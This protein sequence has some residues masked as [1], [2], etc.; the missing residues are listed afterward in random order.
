[1]RST[2]PNW[3]WI[4]G[5]VALLIALTSGGIVTANYLTAAWMASNNARKWAPVFQSVEDELGLPPGLLARVAYQ[6]SR[7]R[8]DIIDG[9]TVSPAGALGIMQLE[10][11]YFSTVNRP[12]PF[13]D[14]D[15][16]DQIVEGATELARLFNVYQDWTR[17]VAAYNAGQ[18][19]INKVLAGTATLK[20]ETIAYL[21]EIS[22]D[23]PNVV[24]PT[25]AA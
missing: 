15:T 5:G 4:A 12:R 21:A 17:A 9:S 13:S 2:I 16:Q 8:Q 18:G 23:L 10:P 14:A 20:P 22:A 3:V 24:N 7:F 19:K 1:M 25:L 6:E 11:E